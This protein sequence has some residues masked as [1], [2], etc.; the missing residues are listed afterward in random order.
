MIA[1][2]DGV[3]RERDAEAH[4]R[5]QSRGQEHSLDP[6]FALVPGVVPAADVP[7]DKAGERVARDEHGDDR[8]PALVQHP[9]DGDEDDEQDQ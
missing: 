9:G 4:P 2:G 8:P 3:E 1:D 7:A 6:R 5:E